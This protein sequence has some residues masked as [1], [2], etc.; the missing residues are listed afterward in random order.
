MFIIRQ[1]MHR[2][3]NLPIKGKVLLGFGAVIIMLLLIGLVLFQAVDRIEHQSEVV[4]EN[5]RVLYS[6]N[7]IE[8]A[9]SQNMLVL[10]QMVESETIDEV[11]KKKRLYYQNTE[12]YHQSTLFID[13]LSEIKQRPE[14]DSLFVIFKQHYDERFAAH[15]LPTYDTMAYY[16]T[17]EKEFEDTFSEAVVGQQK[18]DSTWLD[19]ETYW[20]QRAEISRLKKERK[21]RAHQA[22]AAGYELLAIVDQMQQRIDAQLQ[23]S[24]EERKAVIV[25]TLWLIVIL[26]AAAIVIAFVSSWFLSIVLASS[27]QRVKAFLREIANGTIP[28]EPL[29]E[30]A[31]ELGEVA[32]EANAL[33]DNLEACTKFTKHIGHGQYDVDFHPRDALG[34]ELSLMRS[35]L[36]DIKQKEDDRQRTTTG[37]QEVSGILNEREEMSVICDRLLKHIISFVG[38]TQGIVFLADTK[39]DDVVL[40]AVSTH[41]FGRKKFIDQE[42][43]IGEGLAGQAYL[44]AGPIYLTEI[45][46]E[47]HQIKSGLGSM[48]PGYIYL[49]PLSSTDA[50]EGVL[51]LSGLEELSDND[52]AFLQE[53]S[54]LIG[55]A[56]SS[57]HANEVNR[58]LLAEARQ[59]EQKFREQEEEL[60]QNLEE[61]EATQEQMKRDRKVET[62]SEDSQ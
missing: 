18:N 57:L 11:E 4:D 37:M 38:A 47:Y 10:I 12:A 3:N 44:E 53:I 56:L 29:S 39:A 60:R 7:Q 55:G 32:I 25:S 23:S 34:Q 28:E 50:V 45:P 26:I 21:E 17:L 54:S 48:A 13:S 36:I 40:R 9:V 41:A 5:T 20:A 15:F 24:R 16:R 46:S 30:S 59:M 52:Q 61:L 22:R 8:L 1:R 14:I 35:K 31:D 58:K 51:E 19:Y 43:D 33:R 62:S 49:T 2:L 6:F 42:T 27:I